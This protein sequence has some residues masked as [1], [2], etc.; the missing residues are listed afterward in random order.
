ML[1]PMTLTLYKHSLRSQFA[2]ALD[3]LEDCVRKC[4]DAA[5]GEPIAKYPFWMVVYHTL[6]YTDLYLAPSNR[7]WKPDKGKRGGP[8][9]LHPKGKQELAEEYPSREFAREELLRYIEIVR[10]RLD[11]ALGRET[12]KSLAGSSGF[13]WIEPARADT[14]LYNLR[15]LCHH[16]GQLSAFLHKRQISAR[17]VKFHVEPPKAAK[18]E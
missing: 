15:H 17:W 11:E 18:L 6:C 16:V 7:A 14:Y 9:G 4:P 13:S 2:A 12:G 10:G 1:I 3:M 8:P 5:W